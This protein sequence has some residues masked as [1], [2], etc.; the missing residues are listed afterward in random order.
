[1]RKRTSLIIYNSH[2]DFQ[3]T[4][5]VLEYL[6][7][8][9]GGF[10]EL[11]K[12]RAVVPFEGS[13]RDF[14]HV[15]RHELLHVV[16]N[17][18]IFG[19]N[20][21]S[22][23]SGGGV[24]NFPL[25]MNEGLAEYT[26]LGWDTHADLLMRD[27]TINGE[28]PDLEILDYYSP[29]QGGQSVYR[30]I[31]E[32][33]GDEKIG[34][35][36]AELKSHRGAERGLKAALGMDMKELTE[37]WQLWLKSQYWV[38]VAEREPLSEIATQLTNHRKLKNYF[39]T[40]PAISPSGREIAIMSDRDGY[41]DIFLISSTDGKVIKK[42]L[43]GERT[44]ELEEL[45]WLNPRLSWSPDGKKIALAAKSGKKDALIILDVNTKEKELHYFD[46]MEEI[47]T[48]T[49]SPCGG[50]IAFIGLQN[51]R[52]DIYI[53]HLKEDSLERLTNDIFS[54]FE[55]AWSPDSKNIVFVSERE[56]TEGQYQQTDEISPNDY[57]FHQTDLFIYNIEGGEIRRIT[58]TPWSENCP[59]WANTQDAIIYTSDEQGI[60]NFYV[61]DIE[62]GE[63]KAIT[64][65]L[66]GVFQPS[67][68]KDD[69]RLVFAG[70][71]FGGWDI[72]SISN[73]ID[74][75]DKKENIKPTIFA[76]ELITEWESPEELAETEESP[77]KETTMTTPQEIDSDYSFTTYVFAP[78]Y[79]NWTKSD[80][81]DTLETTQDETEYITE[82]GEYIVR[83]YKTKFTFD[84][85]SN[86]AEYS[87]LW[88]LQATTVFMFSDV[89]GDHRFAIGTEMY[90]DL[91][92]SDYYLAYSYLKKRN[93]FSIVG[94]HYADLWS[95]SYFYLWRLRNYGFDFSL[96]RPFSKFTRLE[97]GMTSYNVEQNLINALTGES[98]YKTTIYTLLPRFAWVCDNTMWSYFYPIDGWRVR[99][100]YTVSPQYRESSLEF[101]TALID[102]RKYFR[103]ND[104]YSFALRLAG[105]LSNGKNAQR[106]FLGGESN[107]LNPVYRRYHDF[108]NP[109]DIYFSSFVT[110]LRGAPFYE[111]EGTRFFLANFEFRYPFIKYLALGWPLPL[112]MGGLQ[113]V[114]F[115]DLGSAWHNNDFHPFGHDNIRGVYFDD[116][117]GG[118]G[119]GTRLFLGYF[120]LKIDVAWSFDLDNISKPQYLF[121]LGTDF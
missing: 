117:V 4:N 32:K 74:L 54:D 118:F 34:E 2:S 42:I 104:E 64:N 91:E 79:E 83:P 97:F 29:Y 107:W 93:N 41:A 15:I 48:A 21:Q 46:K 50:K 111:R 68:S 58:D 38:D 65:V 71:E 77:L 17:E 87:N 81:E 94:F 60:S 115:L 51:D 33:Y 28:I 116:L 7:E 114:T 102:A 10:T 9:V 26:S 44:P 49:W 105:G 108:T 16:I 113:G 39:N 63:S 14:W 13:Y 106:F 82:E 43:K 80:K 119:F 25:W 88:G 1:M 37:K 5:V 11:Y 110:P 75:P 76:K 27:L 53:Y 59:V 84:L 99:F 89:L 103:L 95:L 73:P 72:F 6:P 121:S 67:L 36:W 112:A 101:N 24:I 69:S 35:I 56:I 66:T 45:K 92:N 96:S 78:G 31:A 52:S 62:S 90:I 55:P 19:G 109:E 100:D 23:V 30:Y 18:M 22:V 3:Q 98:E 85:V 40:S 20:M 12:N 70:Y 120:M 47:F 8:G 86:W 61:Y 57:N